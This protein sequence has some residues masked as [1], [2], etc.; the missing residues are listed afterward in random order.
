M[1]QDDY[2]TITVSRAPVTMDHGVRTVGDPVQVGELGMLV[3]P[4]DYER[5][6]DVGRRVVTHGADLYRRGPLP[7]DILPGDLL[8]VRSIT[9]TVTRTPREWRRG[10]RTVGVE[11]HAEQGEDAL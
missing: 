9:M 7:F 5:D 8:T 2:E 10:D 1:I 6:D 11:L 4:G 3:A